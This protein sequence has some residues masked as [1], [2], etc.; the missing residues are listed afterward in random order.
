MLKRLTAA[1][2]TA[3]LALCFTGCAKEDTAAAKN[4]TD[5]AKTATLAL[6]DIE[7]LDNSSIGYGQ[8]VDVNSDNIPLG[9]VNFNKS[10]ADYSAYSYNEDT[11]KITLT[12]DQGY[13]NGY[14]AQI[15]DTLKEK[16]VHAVF[17][18]VLDYAEKNPELV[19]RMIDEGH[20]VGNHSATHPSFPELSVDAMQNEIAEVHE[21]VKEN[22]DYEMTLFRFPSGE[23][24]ERALAA[25]QNAGYS[26][27]F[28]SFAYE[29]WNTDAQP[30]PSEALEK[31]VSHAHNGAVYLLHSVSATNAK[32]LGEAIDKIRAAGYEFN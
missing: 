30:D 27:I 17:F 7:K 32:V 15:L 12:F 22:F 28:W 6:S 29:D 11:E 26:S 9:A 20:T 2:V 5:E 8:G 25:V 1:A 19:E 13:E 16:N 10:Y 24:S 3:A 31:I 23:Y 4:K 14:T 21:Y 18:A